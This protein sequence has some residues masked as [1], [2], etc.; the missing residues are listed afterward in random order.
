MVRS[1]AVSFNVASLYPILYRLEHGVIGATP[2]TVSQRVCS[3]TTARGGPHASRR[4]QSVA[5]ARGT[6]C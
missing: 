6:R 4:R 5:F 3:V 2:T 1:I